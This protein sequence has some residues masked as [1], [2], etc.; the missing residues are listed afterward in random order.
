M[1]RRRLSEHQRRRIRSAQAERGKRAVARQA[2]GQAVT[3]LEAEEPALVLAHHG[4]EILTEDAGGRSLRATARQH[5][6]DLVAGDRVVLQRLVADPDRAVIVARTPRTSVLQRTDA[7]GRTR[8]VAANIDR[9]LIVTAVEPAPQRYLI[10]RYLA[11]AVWIPAE[12]VLVLNKIDLRQFEDDAGYREL[13]D[14]YRR[15]GFPV[16]AI[17]ARRGDG[18]QDLR[19]R[20]RDRTSLIAGQSGVGK[21]SLVKA[22]LPETDIRIGDLSRGAG[23]GRHTTRTSRLYHLPEGGRLI[24]SPGVRGF[25]P[26]DQIGDRP[27]RGFREFHPYLGRCRF[28]DCSH[29]GE[30]GCAVREAVDLGEID[31]RRYESYLR[32][33]RERAE[34]GGGG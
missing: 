32:L 3:G 29:T 30:P 26:G 19:E 15:A 17:S 1:P 8:A 20:L 18:L 28:T 16:V 12:P 5:I 2:D 14:S 9:I 7:M 23:E 27:D 21:S 22:L 25:D 24:D 10:D 13:L 31:P 34:R 11:A 33:R 6:G 4:G